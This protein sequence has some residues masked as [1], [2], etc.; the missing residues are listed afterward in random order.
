MDDLDSGT[1]SALQLTEEGRPAE[2]AAAIRRILTTVGPPDGV[3]ALQLSH[4]EDAG[5]R[6]FDLYVP[7]NHPGGRPPLL[8]M[9]HGGTQNAAD[10]ALGTRMSRLAGGHEM[11]VAYPEQSRA[12]NQG[13]Y[14]NWFS[15]A[16]QR[17]GAGEPSILAGITQRIIDEFGADPR[18]VYVAGMSAG[19][20]MSAVMA[21]TYPGLY[22]AVG[23]HS[24]LAY[25]AADDVSS[26]F[27]AMQH[28]GTLHPGADLPLIVFHGDADNVV[29]PV[30]GEQLVAARLAA[31]SRP[32][33]APTSMRVEV[34]G[35]P[36]TRTVV[37]DEDDKVLAESWLVHGLGHAWSGGDPAGSYA[38]PDGPDAS[39]EMVRFFLEHA[40]DE[41]V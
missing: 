11:L 12:A 2:A 8:V 29:D 25:R 31:T 10:F 9:L 19:G 17:A 36:S 24:G 18:R 39:A 35:R 37:C 22:A 23:V 32:A 30:N 26:G 28:G 16:D 27:A 7:P 38:D 34:G 1:T 6:R 40:R 4:T 15:A 21:A 3:Q 41:E 13:G 33:A 20:A 5:T 14:W